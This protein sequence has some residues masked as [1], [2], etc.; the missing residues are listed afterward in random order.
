VEEDQDV[1]MEE[2]VLEEDA[3]RSLE[4]NWMLEKV[5]FCLVCCSK[6]LQ[7]MCLV[8]IFD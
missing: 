1:G 7:L 8:D 6:E 4:D 3:D 2:E 5:R